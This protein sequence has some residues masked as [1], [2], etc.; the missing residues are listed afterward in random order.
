MKQFKYFSPRTTEEAWKLL[1]KYGNE[2]KV[3]AGG[4]DLLIKM[5][6]REANPNYVIDI[7]QIANLNEIRYD[8]K[9]CCRIGALT[10]IRKIELSPIVSDSFRMLSEAAS[11]LGSV[12]VRNKGT[13]GGNLCN[14]SP[15]ADLAPP[16]IA[17]ESRV[18]IVGKNG[19]RFENLETFFTGPGSTVLKF[20]EIVSE[21]EI[22]S[23]LP[24]SNGTYLKFSPRRAMDLAVVG[25]AVVITLHP[26]NS[27]CTNAKVALGAVAPTPIRI[28]KVEEILEGRKINQSLISE[29]SNLAAEESRPISDIRGSSWYRKEII[30]VLVSR[31]IAQTLE[32]IKL[33]EGGRNNETSG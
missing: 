30:K 21:I 20:D 17:L 8:G 4:T 24:K 11:V 22:P 28:K 32:K 23:L 2:A 29:A 6:N 33:Q 19:E 9:K 27:I 10:K 14:A 5:K 12:Q 15:S 1:T 16:L 18:K 31:A 25:A 13:I 7:K 26:S 3:M